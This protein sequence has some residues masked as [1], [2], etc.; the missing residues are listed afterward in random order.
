M[1][2]TLLATLALLSLV[3]AQCPANYAIPNL[4]AGTLHNHADSLQFTITQP[5][6]NSSQTYQYTLNQPLPSTPTIAIGITP[7]TQLFKT[8]LLFPLDPML[9]TLPQAK[10]PHP[11]SSFHSHIQLLSGQR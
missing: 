9:S 6:A 11:G 5:K 4:V 3:M 1:K 8:S 7:L 10:F 2:L